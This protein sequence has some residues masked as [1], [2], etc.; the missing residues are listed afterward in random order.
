MYLILKRAVN[1]ITSR[2]SPMRSFRVVNRISNVQKRWY[3]VI[4]SSYEY[5]VVRLEPITEEYSGFF[6]GTYKQS[7]T[8]YEVEDFEKEIQKH[9]KDGWRFIQVLPAP[10]YDNRDDFVWDS[11]VV[12]E[13]KTKKHI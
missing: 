4:K 13:R 11:C 6:G 7:R 12:Y 9:A 5:K 8:E 2:F 1:S 10:S 3:S